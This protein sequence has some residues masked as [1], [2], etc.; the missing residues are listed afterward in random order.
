MKYIRHIVEICKKLAP[1]YALMLSGNMFAVVCEMS[2]SSYLNLAKF[3]GADAFH[4]RGIYGQGVSV[5]NLEISVVSE[6]DDPAY[7][8]FLKD[9]NYTTYHPD[10]TYENG[11]DNHPYV[12]LSIMAGYNASY[13]NQEVSTGIAWQANYVS[14]QVATTSP[15]VYDNYAI[16]TYENFFSNGTDVISSSW[17]N[18]SFSTYMVGT[19]LDSYAAKN[20]HTLLVGAA[21]NNGSEGAGHVASPYKNMNCVKVGAL[22]YATGFKTAADFSSYGPNDFYNPVTGET[23]AGVVSAVDIAAPG[24]V[25][26]VNRDGSLGNISGTSFAAPIVASTATLMIS[27][28]RENS[29]PQESRDAR[30]LKAILLNSASKIDGWDNGAYKGSVDVNGKRYDGVLTTT[31]ALDYHSGAGALNAGEALAQYDNFCATSFLDSVG[32]GESHFYD[33]YASEA[34]LEF[35]ATLC[36]YLG[37]DVED[38]TYE[39][40]FLD[41]KEVA[42]IDADLS[43]FANLNLR[44]WYVEGGEEV[45]LAQ[46]ISEYNNVEHLFLELDREGEYRLE[47]F[48]EDL[49]YG[50]SAAES[51]GVAWNLSQVPEPSSCAA[52]F[53]VAILAFAAYR[54]KRIVQK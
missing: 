35:A 52:I 23:I 47:V 39:D 6:D 21:S 5:A 22:D 3:V 2:D 49:V 53:G 48:F 27:Y 32:K 19:I 25:Y 10:G 51:Y 20:T 9:S 42:A 34:G 46:S 30:L 18:E 16:Q 11:G 24:T 13:E 28:S 12:T 33:F 26:S 36:W 37:S 15:F 31:Q 44:L 8:T 43:Y 29:M 40:L 41:G 1:L 38:I 54:K 14:G 7:F 17:V 45:L 4:S 50:D